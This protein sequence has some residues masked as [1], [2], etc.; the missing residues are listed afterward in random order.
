MNEH[1]AERVAIGVHIISPSLTLP[2][3]ILEVL[4]V[5]ATYF[6]REISSCW[7]KHHSLIHLSHTEAGQVDR[8]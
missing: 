3:N 8:A 2:Y 6:M 5:M 7:M 4:C 1:R